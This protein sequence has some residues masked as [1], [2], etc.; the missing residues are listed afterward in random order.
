M[1]SGKRVVVPLSNI[2][3]NE[4]ELSEIGEF[5]LL[6]KGAYGIDEPKKRIAV[7]K[8]DIEIFFVPGRMFDEK[9]NRKGRGKGYFDRFLEK[10]K[11]KKR[12]VGLCYRHQLMNK[13]E[14]NEWDIPVD[15]IILAD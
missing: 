7:T 14:T 15:E 6:Q 5:E 3:K 9:G 2:E 13:L 10:I 8:E 12:I 4:I 11:G 1:F